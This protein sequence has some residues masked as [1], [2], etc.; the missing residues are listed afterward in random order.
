MRQMYGLSF[1][2]MAR[3]KYSFYIMARIASESAWEDSS[4]CECPPNATGP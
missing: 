1:Y 4:P 3:I 2:I